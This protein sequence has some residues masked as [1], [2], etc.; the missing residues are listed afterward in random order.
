MNGFLCAGIGFSLVDLL[1]NNSKRLNLSPVY[2]ALVAFCFS[3]TVGVCWE[4]FEYAADEIVRTDMQKDTIVSSIS[5]VK[6]NEE[7]ENKPVVMK[8]IIAT[9]I[10]TSDGQTY[11]VKDGYLD[12]G[13]NDTMKDLFVNLIGAVVFSIIGYIY[14][15]VRDKNGFASNFIPQKID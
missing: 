5:S 11:V 2:V 14:V 7:R 15:K 1:N 3:M 10:K 6:L 4:F 8:N 9:E 12:I 13:I